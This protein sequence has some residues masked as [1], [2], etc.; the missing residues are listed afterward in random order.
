MNRLRWIAVAASLGI[1]V[2]A[3]KADAATEN[4]P[5][6]T[7]GAKASMHE[8]LATYVAARQAEFDQISAGRKAQLEELGKYI[9]EQRTADA[10]V[11]LIFVCT[12][13]SRRSHMA[14]VWAA[15]AAEIYGIKASTY[16]GG[17]E[18]T[19]FNPRTVAAVKR[20]GFTVEKTTDGENPIYHVR[21]SDDR[22]AL[23]CFSKKYDNAPNPQKDFAAIMV[24]DGADRACPIVLGANAR[25][26]IA[27]VD[28]KAAD[29]T[30]EEAAAYDERCAQIAR[31]M[32]YAMSRVS[33]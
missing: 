15:V 8:K 18:S 22:P 4:Q 30:P 29:D 11:R 13:N 28:P 1:A 33:G 31:E 32:L 23:T 19:A 21:F 10:P 2:A 24:C 25:L 5:G 17:T 9:R 6:K 12:H 20:A 14:H 16:S 7:G 26:A 3:M 27:Y